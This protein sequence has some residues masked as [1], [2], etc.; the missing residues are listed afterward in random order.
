MLSSE[1]W[2]R[3]TFIVLTTA[4]LTLAAE[5][6]AQSSSIGKRHRAQ[7]DAEQIPSGSTQ[8]STLGQRT[9]ESHSIIAVTLPPPRK[10]AVHDLVTI[11]VREQ[12]K[13]EA[14]GE[15]EAG[16]DFDIK[17][18]L[19]AFAKLTN[20]GL[21]A[22]QF[23][24]GKPTI[25]YKF[26]TNT[27]GEADAAREDNFTTRITARIVDVKP[28]GNLVLEA[29][30]KMVHD[31]ESPEVMLTGMCRSQD[32]TPDNTVLSTQMADLEIR[33]HNHGEVRNSTR[34]GWIPRLLD[35]LRPF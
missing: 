11:I 13:F 22:S 15:T 7:Q 2:R 34:R 30:R 4:V 32:I 21:G 5:A 35:E 20:G 31:D 19:E 24:R 14:S 25:D 33:V 29:R 12:K 1:S 26:S 16:K 17:S 27:K 3:R 9:I 8:T 18:E 23:T 28:N 6:A 10:Y